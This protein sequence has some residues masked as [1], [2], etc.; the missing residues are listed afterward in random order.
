MVC[1]KPFEVF[2][3]LVDLA[4]AGSD[5]VQE[6]VFDVLGM[7]GDGVVLPLALGAD[8][9]ETG[10]PEGGEMARYFGLNLVE[11]GAEITDAE[12]ALEEEVEYSEPGGVG[13]CPEEG[14]GGLE[15]CRHIWVSIYVG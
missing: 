2:M 8:G 10:L 5:T 14:G 3:Q 6:H 7:G 12:F 11:G 9:D 15:G 1:L 13:E 4:E